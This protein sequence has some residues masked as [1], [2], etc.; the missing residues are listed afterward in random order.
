MPP[1]GVAEELFAELIA[2]VEE[3]MTGTVSGILTDPDDAADAL[4]NALIYV[5]KNLKKIH[6]HPNPH[7]YILK[8]CISAS[9]DVLRR[10]ARKAR[11]E[12][13]VL[14]G[15]DVPGAETGAA[16]PPNQTMAAI[17]RGIAALPRKQAQAVLLRLLRDEPYDHIGRWLGCSENTARSH[18]SKGLARLRQHLSGIVPYAAEG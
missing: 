10:N 11:R 16:D 4:Q 2:P 9:Y 15:A 3:R 14:P 13:R 18:Y 6:R 8:A 12:V 1:V 7:G 5:W 17:R